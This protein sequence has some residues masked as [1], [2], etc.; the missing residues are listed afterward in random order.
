MA[1]PLRCR[2]PPPPHTHKFFFPATNISLRTS[3]PNSRTLNRVL[4]EHELLCVE[5]AADREPRASLAVGVEFK[6]SDRAQLRRHVVNAIDALCTVASSP[7]A[8][9]SYSTSAATSAES[10]SLRP[11]TSPTLATPSTFTEKGN[12]RCVV[13]EHRRRHA[14]AWTRHCHVLAARL[15]IIHHVQRTVEAERR[16]V[17]P[18]RATAAKVPCFDEVKKH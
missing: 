6:P 3:S 11:H 15:G 16:P 17:R 1:S 7:C 9:C 8:A 14:P 5:L 10:R 2:Q 12:V 13:L 4:T 18:T